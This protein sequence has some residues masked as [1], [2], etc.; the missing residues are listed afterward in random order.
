MKRFDTVDAYIDHHEQ[1]N[2]ELRLLREI[3]NSTGLDETVKWGAPAYIFK[4]K[5]VVGIGAFKSYVGLWFH[6]GA[7]LKDEAKVLINAQKDVTKALRQWR[8]EAMD[9]ID[10]DLIKAYILESIDNFEKGKVLKPQ[11]NKKPVVIPQE[12][13]DAF[14]K[15]KDLEASFKSL[16]N[17]CQREY[18]EHVAEAK[19]EEARLRRL[20]KI[21]PMILKGGGLH[22]KYKNC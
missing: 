7:L 19:K 10:K 16:S 11:R 15:N 1:Y 12:L 6:Q 22:D 20:A 8:F 21:T 14:A 17:A 9:D 5:N 13:Q 3:L 4:G 18:A 2:N